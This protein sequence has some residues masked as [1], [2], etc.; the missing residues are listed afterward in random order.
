VKNAADCRIA[1]YFCEDRV[2][3]EGSRRV[4]SIA[5]ALDNINKS[6]QGYLVLK[7]LNRRIRNRT[8]GGVGG[9]PLN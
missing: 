4:R 8:Y 1:D 6:V 2:E 7:L 5:T 9:R 3:L